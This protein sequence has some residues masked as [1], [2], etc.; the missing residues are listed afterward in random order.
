MTDSTGVWGAL[1]RWRSLALLVPGVAFLAIA[2]S[3]AFIAMANTGLNL[4]P[5]FAFEPAELTVSA[6]ETVRWGFANGGHNASRR[7]G[8]ADAVALPDDA[9]PFASYGPEQDP[10]VTLVSR[11]ETHEHTFDVPGQDTDACI[12][13]VDA[14][15][16]GTIRIE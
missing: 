5:S 6:G 9:E 14:G 1:E 12:P 2:I 7:P 8:D 16:A 13:H 11:G 4:T 3:D 15:M 10:E